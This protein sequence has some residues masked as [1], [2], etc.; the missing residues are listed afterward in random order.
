MNLTIKNIPDK[1]YRTLKKD[2]AEKGRS[3]NAEVIVALTRT[4]EEVERRLQMRESWDD[5][6]RFVASLPKLPSSV[7]LI[8]AD[9]RRH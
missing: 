2:A 8:R 3:L 7:P 6:N 1:V 9:R 4:A 5:L